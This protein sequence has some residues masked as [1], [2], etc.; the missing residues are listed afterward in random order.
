MGC[1][2][3][4][5]EYFDLVCRTLGIENRSRAVMVGDNLGTDILG[6]NLAGMDT[7][8]YNPGRLSGNGRVQP[9]W[10]VD[11][12]EEIRAIILDGEHRQE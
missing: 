11:R 9:T 8:W 6:G 10:T 3:P 1:Q 4:Q 2:K 7:I 5:R 12:L